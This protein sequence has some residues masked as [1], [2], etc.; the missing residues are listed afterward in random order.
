ML[1]ICFHQSSQTTASDALRGYSV[2]SCV[3]CSVACSCNQAVVCSGNRDA[4]AFQGETLF[5]HTCCCTPLRR[6]GKYCLGLRPGSASENWEYREYS[7][8]SGPDARTKGQQQLSKER[9]TALQLPTNTKLSVDLPLPVSLTSCTGSAARTRCCR[10]FCNMRTAKHPGRPSSL[11][12]RGQSQPQSHS[13]T[14]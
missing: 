4:T 13:G 12:Q 2:H 3:R 8:S 11:Q 9:Q 14:S 7:R 6:S 1:D 10:A 5:K